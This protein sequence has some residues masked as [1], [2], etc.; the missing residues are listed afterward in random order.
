MDAA[1]LSEWLDRHHVDVVR[2]FATTLDGPAIGKYVH[3]NKFSKTLP[4]GHALSDMALSMDLSGFP[5]VTFWHEERLG[6]FGDIYLRPDLDTL[7]SDGTDPN[8][9]HCICDFA[10]ESGEKHPEE[11]GR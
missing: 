9:G 10:T 6:V 2:T 11:N 3:R 4:Q 7:I 8:L 5:H 1:E